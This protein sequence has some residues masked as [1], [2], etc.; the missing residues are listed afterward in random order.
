[1]Q[2]GE[3]FKM[4]KAVGLFNFA[5]A[6]VELLMRV[7]RIKTALNAANE[8]ITKQLKD[9]LAALKPEELERLQEELKVLLS[10][11]EPDKDKINMLQ[12]RISLLINEQNTKYKEAEEC[13]F[14]QSYKDIELE[15]I[16][17]EELDILRKE[18]RELMDMEQGKREVVT[19]NH[20][21]IDDFAA[22][23]KLIK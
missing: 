6:K 13:T 15:T 14:G 11:P 10:E 18:K 16:S 5:G 4:N 20:F 21:S 22:L 1:M 8:E 7:I 17:Q 3:I 9:I 12:I 19:T 2:K 23:A